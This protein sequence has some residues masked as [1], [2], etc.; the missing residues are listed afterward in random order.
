MLGGG[1]CLFLLRRHKVRRS[2]VKQNVGS[3][4]Q[5]T[6]AISS[7]A[8]VDGQDDGQG[9]ELSLRI[10]SGRCSALH[11]KM[12]EAAGLLGG[13][14]DAMRVLFSVAED[15]FAAA[16][17]ELVFGRPAQAAL[18][19]EHY[20]CVASEAVFLGL[21]EGTAAI[22][23]EVTTGGTDDDRECLDY[24]LHAEAG[25]SDR[26]YQG[27]VRRDCDEYGR[28]LACRTV[29]DGNGVVRGMRLADFI[30]HP[31]ARHANL[32]EAHVVALRLYTT[33]AR[34]PSRTCVSP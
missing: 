16:P 21:A 19:V 25:A 27:G 6:Y 8:G 22:V 20:M 7:G 28:V 4:Q 10:D 1:L 32:T 5:A 9:D 13:G 12:R 24:I 26:T 30:A 23:R 3:L 33:Q 15:R 14:L 34:H 18:G 17:R 29:T 11:I 2:R 31:S